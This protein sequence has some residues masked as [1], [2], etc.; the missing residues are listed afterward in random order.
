MFSM[1]LAIHPQDVTMHPLPQTAKSWQ[2]KITLI[3]ELLLLTG[4]SKSSFNSSPYSIGFKAD[5]MSIARAA[6]MDHTLEAKHFGWSQ[7]WGSL[8]PDNNTW[9]AYTYL[10]TED[11]NKHLFKPP[12]SRFLC[13]CSCIFILIHTSRESHFYWT[14]KVSYT[15]CYLKIL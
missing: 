14:G 5:R 6:I 11:G 7:V 2:T 15:A 1:I 12:Y 8:V 3:W 4:G 10:L 9:T 13:Y